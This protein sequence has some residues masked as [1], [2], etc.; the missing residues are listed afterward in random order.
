MRVHDAVI[1]HHGNHKP[2]SERVPVEQSDGRHGVRQQSVPQAIESLG[3]EAWSGSGVF[4][5]EAIGVEFWEAGCGDDDAWGV[6]G[7]EDVES[8]VEGFD[9][10]LRMVNLI[11]G[12][13]AVEATDSCETV[14]WCTR[15]GDKVDLCGWLSHGDFAGVADGNIEE[16][17]CH[18]CDLVMTPQ[19]KSC[20][21]KGKAGNEA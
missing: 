16:S 18:D 10:G 3:E 11:V 20:C 5:V 12:D 8:K 14:V 7:L 4:E 9:E 13:D 21:D 17:V 1:V 19:E 6:F 15:E 2:T